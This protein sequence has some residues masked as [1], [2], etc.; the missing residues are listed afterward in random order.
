MA[1]VRREVQRVWDL[2]RLPFVISTT[3]FPGASVHRCRRSQ[4][5][6]L[7]TIAS[8]CEHLCECDCEY[9]Y[10]Q[11]LFS[12]IHLPSPV[13]SIP[14][15]S[16]GSRVILFSFLHF[17]YFEKNQNTAPLTSPSLTSTGL[18]PVLLYDRATCDISR[19]KNP[20]LDS[21]SLRHY[22]LDA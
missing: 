2:V 4:S 15:A 13:H 11:L 22:F 12:F 16:T 8:N 7:H 14:F 9:S 1:F 21:D 19:R 5:P 10:S 17:F 18:V 3:P 20:A 6:L